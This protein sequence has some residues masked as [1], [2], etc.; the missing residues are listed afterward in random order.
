MADRWE[1]WFE[2][3][4]TLLWEGA[5]APGFRKIPQGIFFTAFGIPFLG[6]GLFVSG[7]GLGYLF[8]FAGDWSPWHAGL[9]IV[10]GAFGVPFM[11]VGAGMVFG[12]WVHDYL[13]PRRVRYA[14]SDRNAYIASRMWKRSMDV[15]PIQSD[16]RIETEE[17]RDGTMS[18]WFRVDAYKDSDGDVHATRKGFEALTDGHAVY[19]TLRRL[20]AGENPAAE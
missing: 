10:L 16:M 2:P 9:G 8:G 15:L 20:Q 18:V 7:L 13:K 1:D 19:R 6:G 14:L 4:E 5:P 17:H 12:P 11:A 3:G